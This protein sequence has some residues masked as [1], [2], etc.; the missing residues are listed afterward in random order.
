M[1]HIFQKVTYHL[2]ITFFQSNI[3]LFCWVQVFSGE[4]VERSA[5]FL[6]ISNYIAIDFSAIDIGGTLHKYTFTY[7]VF[8]GQFYILSLQSSRLVHF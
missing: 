6:R 2:P 5:L 7:V 1:L 4:L 8:V 3:I